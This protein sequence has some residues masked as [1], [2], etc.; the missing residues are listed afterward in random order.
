MPM[1][2]RIEFFRSVVSAAVLLSLLP[3]LSLAGSF[4][5]VVTNVPVKVLCTPAARTG[6]DYATT[7][8]YTAGQEVR[9]QGRMFLCVAGGTS[10]NLAGYALT[11]S[12]RD[13]VDNTVTWRPGLTKS[14]KG[15]TVVNGSTNAFLYVNDTGVPG[16]GVRLNPNGGS[17]MVDLESCPQGNIWIQSSTAVVSTNFLYEW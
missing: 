12:D 2:K 5:S 7:T 15:L 6:T 16:A 9:S 14:R 10:T 3:C 17:W 13:V 8:V 4:V 1:L 11:G